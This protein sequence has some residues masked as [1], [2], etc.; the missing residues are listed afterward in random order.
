[1]C[2]ELAGYEIKRGKYI[3]FRAPGQER[4]TREKTIGAN[5]T[6][7]SIKDRIANRPIKKPR[8]EIRRINLLI[9]IQ[10]CIK[11]QES[12]GYEH[13]AKIN[14]LKQASK[15]LNFLTEHNIKSYA[16]LEQATEKIH[17]DFDKVSE[18][19]KSTEKQMNNTAVLM[20]NGDTYTELKP[21]YDKYR[22]AKNKSDFENK[23]RREIILFE[24]HKRLWL[25]GFS[26]RCP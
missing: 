7:D 12:K 23:H 19:I 26:R 15:T 20:K 25:C 8:P 6:E 1:M 22:T 17:T 10:N 21:V 9:D 3:S 24:Q 14:N 4:F 5:Y 13:W 11:A 2:M 16:E 18:Q